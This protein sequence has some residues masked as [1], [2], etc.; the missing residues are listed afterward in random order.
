MPYRVLFSEADCFGA[1]ELSGAVRWGDLVSAIRALYSHP[2]WNRDFSVLWDGRAIT[3]LDILPAD[4]PSI[5][6]VL[7]ET[8]EA[9]AGGRAAV[10]TRNDEDAT[11]ALLLA[12]M[13]PPSDRV[14]G[15]FDGLEEAL[16]FLGR[17][18]L[19]EGAQVLASS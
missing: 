11:M 18:S 7:W 19:P 2:S 17:C 5:K 16:A 14:V 15:T 4:L 8:A 9:R 12:H 10:V 13:G 3:S 6:A 1:V